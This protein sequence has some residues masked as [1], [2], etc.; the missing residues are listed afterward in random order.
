MVRPA[1][2]LVIAVYIALGA[3][4]LVM[5][6]GAFL[7]SEGSSGE[8]MQP[9][10]VAMTLSRVEKEWKEQAIAFVDCNATV[11]K[12]AC[13][14]ASASF[15][16][17][18]S[19]VVSA[20]LQGSAGRRDAASEYMSDVCSQKS[21]AGWQ[22][23]R[24]I[25][26]ADAIVK[27]GM[28][29]DSYGNREKLDSTKLCGAFWLK[30]VD[31]E[32]VREEVE[33]A[34]R[35]K[36]EAEEAAREKR[37]AEEAAAAKKKAQEE[38]AAA[39]KKAKEEAKA[40][41][42]R[43][44]RDAKEQEAA[45]ARTRAAETAARLAQKKAEAEAA[46]KAAQQRLEEAALAEQEHLQLKAEH[47]KAEELLRNATNAAAMH[48]NISTNKATGETRLT[49]NTKDEGLESTAQEVAP[50][51]IRFD[52]GASLV[53]VAAKP[54]VG[55]ACKDCKGKMKK[56]EKCWFWK[57]GAIKGDLQWC[58]GTSRTGATSCANL[59]S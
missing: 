4:A 19:T 5:R 3:N 12:V 50:R 43:R 41:A 2:A 18:C 59:C 31:A 40:E 17:S 44:A 45:E 23:L 56:G 16:K 11:D 37:E 33:R 46:Q 22:K 52:C 20:V 7:A 48:A 26:L 55:E 25:D 14:D 42:E 51:L 58:S 9:E 53:R 21:L 34:A 38:A 29:G 35:E 47:A 32:R 6:G 49:M 10:V 27:H 39:L 1:I 28:T 36:R 24:C 15:E 30:F 8:R 57:C 54:T 13:K